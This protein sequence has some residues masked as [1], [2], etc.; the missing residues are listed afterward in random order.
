[1]SADVVIVGAGYAGI[2]A[3]KRLAAVDGVRV[4]M[5][6]PSPYF[7]ERIRL[8][9]YVAGNHPARR[10][11]R[12]VLPTRVHLTIDTVSVIDE[13]NHV[14]HT[15]SGRELSYGHLVYTPGSHSDAHDIR[16]AAEHAVSL[17]TWTEAERA[18]HRLR[19]LPSGAVVTV[20]GGG[21]TGIEVAAELAENGSARVHLVTGELGHSLSAAARVLLRIALAELGVTVV[22]Q[23]AVAEIGDRKIALTDGTVL[24]TDLAVTTTAFAPSDLARGSGMEVDGSGALL[25]DET[26]LSTT[27]PAIVGAGDGVA[28]GA[29]P[30]RM[31]CQAAI[32]SGIHAAETVLRLRAGLSPK[33]LR[34][35]YIG[36]AVSLGRKNALVQFTDFTDRPLPQ[37]VLTHGGAALLKEQICRATVRGG[38]LGPVRYRWS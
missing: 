29:D 20:V 12:A 5:V 19:A 6:N 9:Q 33:P 32:P 8:H 35:R 17:G 10:P 31:S 3:A 34:R 27:S 24:S 4:T 22:E 36:Q 14:V 37:L 28:L 13:R 38:Q 2:S 1:M 7:V 26:L 16:G 15:G 11:L 18:R 21:L 25:V 30:L 23:V